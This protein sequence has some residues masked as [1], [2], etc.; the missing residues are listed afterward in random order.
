MNGLISLHP[1]NGIFY[2]TKYDHHT[3]INYATL[4][5]T[6][7]NGEYFYF[8]DDI[9]M[10]EDISKM[11]EYIKLDWLNH[12]KK[13]INISVLNACIKE[14]QELFE[15]TIDEDN[16]YQKLLELFKSLRRDLIMSGLI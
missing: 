16:K 14:C 10:I 12:N 11:P 9:E 5:A 1:W 2:F 13:P 8:Y 7:T 3:L 4:I 15:S 6:S